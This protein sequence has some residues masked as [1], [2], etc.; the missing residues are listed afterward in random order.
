MS[1][2]AMRSSQPPTTGLHAPAAPRAARPA[3]LA[4]RPNSWA[5]DAP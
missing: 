4:R 1:D 3:A 2:P 5:F